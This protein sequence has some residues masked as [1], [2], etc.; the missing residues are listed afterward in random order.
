MKI[1]KRWLIAAAVVLLGAVAVPAAAVQTHHNHRGRLHALS[2]KSEGSGAATG[3][4]PLSGILPRDK[5]TE[6]SGIEIN[7]SK[8]YARLPIY[9]GTAPNP[10]TGKIE[11]VWYLLLDASDSG[12]HTTSA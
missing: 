9:P 4:G 5:L 3:L 1:R 11:R 7:L 12:W 2:A 8:E 10:K 6:E